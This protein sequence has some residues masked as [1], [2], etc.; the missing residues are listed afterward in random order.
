MALADWDFSAGFSIETVEDT[1]LV[2]RPRDKTSENRL[3][4]KI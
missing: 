4:M 1:V 3:L 2:L